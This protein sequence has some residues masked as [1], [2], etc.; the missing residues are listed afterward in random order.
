MIELILGLAFL[1]G[2]TGYARKQRNKHY[3]ITCPRCG[4]LVHPNTTGMMDGHTHIT[5]YKYKCTCGWNG[6]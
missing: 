1:G 5:K 6:N 3:S 2:V 4:K